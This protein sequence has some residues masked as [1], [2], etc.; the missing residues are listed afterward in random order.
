M[1]RATRFFYIILSFVLLMTV[2]CASVPKSGTALHNH[3]RI[4]AIGDVHGSYS[5]LV[6]IMKEASLINNE[7]RWIGGKALMVQTGDLLDRGSEVHKVLDLLMNLQ[8]DAEAAGGKVVV[9]MG[10]H[11]AMNIFGSRHDVNPK[12]YAD[13]AGP[14]SEKTQH[15]AFER[16]KALFGTSESPDGKDAETRQQDWLIRHPPG[17]VEYTQSMGPGGRYGK[18]LRNLPV[19]FR[20]GG[21][22]FYHAGIS[23]EYRDM[24]LPDIHR[25]VIHEINTF[26]ENKSY[27]MNLGIVEQWFNMTEIMAVV[28]SIIA[29]A[30]SEKLPDSLRDALPHLKEIKT[31]FDGIYNTSPLMIDE[32]PL[33]FRGL[34]NWSDERIDSYLP[35]WLNK[36]DAWRM[37][38]SHTPRAEGRIQ[39]RLDGA[40]FIIDTGMETGYYKGGRASA[41]EIRNDEVTAV[42]EAGERRQFPPPE[43]TYGQDYVWTDPE[44]IP[45]PFDTLD[46]ILEFLM[47]ADPIRSETIF[48]GV[49]RPKKVLLK[50][51]ELEANAAFRH[52]SQVLSPTEVS[53]DYFRDSYKGEIAAFEINRLLG[54]N[55]M[56]PTV[57]RAVNDREGT[58]QLWAEGTTS[59]KG[60]GKDDT[61]PDVLSWNK[62]KWDMR[63]FDN[64]I[65]NIDR[66]QTNLLIDSNWRLILIDHTR[67]FAISYSLPEPEKIVRCS[68]G[69]WYNLRHLD[70]AVVRDRLSPFLSRRE[71]DDVIN[72]RDLLVRLIQDLIDQKGE[73]NVLF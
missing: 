72:R 35:E 3:D 63:V 58:L 29:S 14:D 56:P 2:S 53:G 73:E 20:Y 18:W 40:V 10:N 57:Y 54:L 33:W 7:N 26:D 36:N 64:L 34:A 17:F 60:L 24:P 65:N 25:T 71:I 15:Q 49:N 28:D 39:S 66:N 21:T 19:M 30:E 55:N 59:E 6:S 47:N 50:K 41:L 68:R 27:L 31:F 67:C 46:D 9:I 44:G 23:P 32:G 52:Q 1:R 38:V 69:L 48:T 5:G 70:E 12:A 61:P 37:V 11:E 42:Y 43:I 62:Q 4:I 51:G 45:L 13:F 16:W 22:V 8:D